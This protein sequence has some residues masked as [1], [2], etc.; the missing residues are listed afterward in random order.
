MH[1]MS[2]HSIAKLEFWQVTAAGPTGLR[3]SGAFVMANP[4][5]GLRVDA[6]HSNLYYQP[7]SH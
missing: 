7:S 3:S 1:M 6:T 5:I 2:N 4:V